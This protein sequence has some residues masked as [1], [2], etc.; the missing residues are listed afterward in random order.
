[1]TLPIIH[2][3]TEEDSPFKKCMPMVQVTGN[4]AD[5]DTGYI[6]TLVIIRFG[7]L[8]VSYTKYLTFCKIT[9]ISTTQDK[10]VRFN[11]FL[12]KMFFAPWLALPKHT[13]S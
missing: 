3:P 4:L 8:L 5:Y 2:T 10:P 1:M 12:G 9:C 6:D 7:N 11:F 13:P